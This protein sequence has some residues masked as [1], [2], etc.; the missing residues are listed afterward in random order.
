VRGSLLPQGLVRNPAGLFMQSDD[1]LDA[2]H[3]IE[4]FLR[5]APVALRLRALLP[6]LVRDGD[7]AASR[8]GAVTLREPARG[9]HGLEVARQRRGLDPHGLRQIHRPQRP[10]MKDVRQQRVLRSLESALGDLC[11][12]VACKLAHQAPQPEIGTALRLCDSIHADD[13][14]Y[15]H[16]ICNL[17]WGI[18]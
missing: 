1:A 2:K 18:E 12:V 11:V 14:S 4:L 6:P 13:C 3:F 15:N 16:C 8:I 17:F 7:Q 5:G 9:N 10:Q